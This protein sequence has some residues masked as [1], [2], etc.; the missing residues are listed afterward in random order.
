MERKVIALGFYK[1]G[2]FGVNSF[3]LYR[4]PSGGF[5]VHDHHADGLW[6]GSDVRGAKDAFR[7]MA[8]GQRS[9]IVFRPRPVLWDY[10][11]EKARNA[12]YEH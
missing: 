10:R 1:N 9:E 2:A 12:A 6:Y 11:V 8:A 4:E 5:V 3:S 7:R